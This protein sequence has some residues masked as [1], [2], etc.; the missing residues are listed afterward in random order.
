VAA[1]TIAALVVV[2]GRVYSSAVLHNGPTLKLRDAWRHDGGTD[3][4]QSNTT[5]ERHIMEPSSRRSNKT[6]VIAL[7]GAIFVAGLL[8]AVTGDVIIGVAVGAALFALVDRAVKA[9]GP[10]SS[11][12]PHSTDASSA[13]P[14]VPRH[15]AGKR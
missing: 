7:A 6:V 14:G 5:T 2:G 3:I 13:Q 9:W 15:F 8:V 12:P 11:T 1:A 10:P 4:A